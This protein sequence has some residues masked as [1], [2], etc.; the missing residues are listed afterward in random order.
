MDYTLAV[1]IGGT[2]IASAILDENKLWVEEHVQMSDVSSPESMYKSM[3][4]SIYQVL[5][6]AELNKY[7]I[8]KIG[9][10]IPGQVDI[11]LGIAIYSNNL[12]WRNFNLGIL[13]KN[14][15]PDSEI[16]FE[17]DVAAAGLGEL[18][19]RKEKSELFVYVTIS[20]G[21]ASCILYKAK[22]LRGSGMAGEIGFFPVE[23]LSLENFASGSGMEKELRTDHHGISLISAFDQWENGD[24]V[25]GHFFH[26]KAT[27][28]AMA[29]F[30]VT[31]TLDPH[32]IVIGGGVVNNQPRF[33][34][35]IQ[36][37]FVS[38]CT[39]P[40]QESW[41]KKLEPSVLKS[42]SG[43]YGLACI[44]LNYQKVQTSEKS[45]ESL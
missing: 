23:R 8:K 42:R 2:K 13:L 32:K 38:L 26:S 31:A 10:A 12:P 40:L 14:E 24:I 4:A 30:Q 1:D 22:P 36:N 43:L 17:H 9:I 45:F 21:I 25:L 16:G 6:K 27:Q 35:L 41:K 44:E 19:F 39:H 3:L 20:T 7:Q 11:D 18:K 29:L 28:I 15:F 33:Y 5:K 37:Q 34:E